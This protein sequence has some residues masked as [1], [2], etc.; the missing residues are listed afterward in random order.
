MLLS[1]SNRTSLVA[2]TVG[3]LLK[4]SRREVVSYL[5]S[6]TSFPL[7][8]PQACTR[9]ITFRLETRES[10]DTKTL[11]SSGPIEWCIYIYIHI[12]RWSELGHNRYPCVPG[13]VKKYHADASVFVTRVTVLELTP[14][15][16]GHDRLK[17]SETK[18]SLVMKQASKL[19]FCAFGTM[20][21]GVSGIEG[22]EMKHQ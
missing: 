11:S 2:P 4:M 14:D 18:V 10:D 19:K 1:I 7:P 13:S 20:I 5:L 9:R 17:K 22:K 16:I 21:F 8:A 12:Y 6:P 3:E 15:P